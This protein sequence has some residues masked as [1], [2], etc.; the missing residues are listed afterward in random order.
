MAWILTNAVAALLLP[1]L[2]LFMLGAAGWLALKIRRPVLGKLLIFLAVTF[3]W[4]LSTPFF[5][6]QLI[7]WVEKQASAASSCPPQAIVALGAGTY[8]NAPEYGGDTVSGL[9][10]ERLR[11]AAHLHRQTGLPILVTGGYPDKGEHSE[12]KLMRSVLENEFGVPAKWVEDRSNNTRENALLSRELLQHEGIDSIYLVTQAWHMARAQ[13]A[14]AKAGFCIAPAATGHRTR[15][16]ITLLS[17]LPS[18]KA[19]S[20]SHTALHEAIGI[21]WYALSA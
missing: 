15:N 5:S 10:L 16:R 11:L 18:A 20:E 3:L 7:G 19:L 13:K 8:F 4:L 1:P 14:F 2:G 6:F 9:G 12:A 21:V 17:F